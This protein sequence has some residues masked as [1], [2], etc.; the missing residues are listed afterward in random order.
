MPNLD[1]RGLFGYLGGWKAAED[2]DMGSGGAP[3]QVKEVHA[4]HDGAWQKVWEDNLPPGAP[5]GLAIA[6]TWGGATWVATA[7]WATPPADVDLDV[8][9]VTWTINGVASAP[10]TQSAADLDAAVNVPNSSTVAVSVRLRDTFGLYTVTPSTATGTAPVGI[11]SASAAQVALD[12]VAVTFVPPPLAVQVRAERKIDGGAAQQLTLSRTSP[13]VDRI[14]AGHT[15]EYRLAGIGGDGRLGPWSA[16]TSAATTVTP[17]SNLHVTAWSYSSV[18][19]AWDAI[20]AVS[21]YVVTVTPQGGVP[22]QT[23]VAAGVTSLTFG[24]TQDTNYTV[25]VRGEST[26]DGITVATAESAAIKPA[27]GHD[28]YTTA[29]PWASAIKA[30]DL[31]R[32]EQDGV[33]VPAGVALHTIKF[34]SIE[35]TGAMY[36]LQSSTR[37]LYYVRNG[38]K[39]ERAP[40][41]KPHPWTEQMAWSAGPGISGLRCEG[42]G[43][44]SAGDDYRLIGN[45]RA[46]GDTLTDHPAVANGYWT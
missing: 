14:G 46:W 2:V 25:T 24:V 33:S 10:V 36:S 42:T 3:V 34:I 21:R 13:F 27:I 19:V 30:I 18:S 16:W 26:Y 12:A 23:T 40:T 43:W 4:R 15:V 22:A 11:T 6:F 38:A 31:K 35:T 9:E 8:A 37:Q 41:N 17:P 7:S 32:N 1:P 28:A 39:A 20:P 29:V 45:I 44:S 5:L